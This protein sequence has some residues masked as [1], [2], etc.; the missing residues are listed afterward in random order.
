MK[1][2]EVEMSNNNTGKRQYFPKVSLP[3]DR[4]P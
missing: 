1:A 3:A 4:H 2:N